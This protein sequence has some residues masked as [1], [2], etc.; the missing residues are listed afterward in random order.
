MACIWSLRNVAMRKC[1]TAFRKW[2]SVALNS[3]PRTQKTKSTAQ[4]AQLFSSPSVNSHA[5]MPSGSPESLITD[6]SQRRQMIGTL[7]DVG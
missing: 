3:P 7:W 1:G 2:L 4:P 6:M 5:M